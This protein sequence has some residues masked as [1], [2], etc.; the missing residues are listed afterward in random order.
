M[1]ED[2][3]NDR[4]IDSNDMVPETFTMI[5]EIVGSLNIGFNWKGFDARAILTAY[6]NRSVFLSPAVSFSGWSNLATHEVTYAWGYYND[7]PNDERNINAKYPRPAWGSYQA[8]D[9]DRDTGT[10]KNDIW[11]KSGDYLSLR[12]VEIGYSLPKRLVAKANMT[13]VRFYAIGYNLKNW[14]P[15][16][17]VDCDPEKPMSYC[18]WYPKVN[19]FSFGINITF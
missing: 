5:P 3:N 11:I 19:S 15:Q 17:P 12:N 1:F 8:V 6:I 14:A 9:S 2:V 4:Q 16:L 18:W 7:N 10:Y 13:G